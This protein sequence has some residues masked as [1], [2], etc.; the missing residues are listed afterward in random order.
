MAITF[1]STYFL[2]WLIALFRLHI[3]LLA[4]DSALAVNVILVSLDACR[5]W[6]PHGRRRAGQ[7]GQVADL[8]LF[9]RRRRFLARDQK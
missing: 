9:G 8:D 2:Y 7:V 3:D 1:S 4:V 5:V 6:L